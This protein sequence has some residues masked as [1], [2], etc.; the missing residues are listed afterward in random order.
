MSYFAPR[1]GFTCDNVKNY[2]IVLASGQIINAN[3]DEHSDLLVALRGGGNNFGVV[4]R[5]DIRT[6]EQGKMWGGGIFYDI[7]AAP[8]H[9]EAFYNFNGNPNYDEYAAVIQSF[10][11]APGLGLGVG[12][13]Y[14]YTKPET[15]PAALS[16]FLAVK[17][18]LLNTER[19]SNLTNI[20]IEQAAFSPPGVRY[21]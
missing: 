6:F 18:E 14:E 8:Q 17:P 13:N 12:N 19:I 16:E 11:Y 5:V 1:V 2:E 9:L 7:S 21:V 4:T 3:K 15:N 10:G 20:T